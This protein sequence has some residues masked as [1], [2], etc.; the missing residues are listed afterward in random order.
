LSRASDR[1]ILDTSKFRAP[2]PAA[3]QLTLEF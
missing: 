1:H 3:S 2:G